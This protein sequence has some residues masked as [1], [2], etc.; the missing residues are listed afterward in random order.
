M[1]GVHGCGACSKEG[2]RKAGQV[3]AKAEVED[4]AV[5]KQG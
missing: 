5:E 2:G 4:V 1:H 3:E